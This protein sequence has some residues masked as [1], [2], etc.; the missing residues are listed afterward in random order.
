MPGLRNIPKI[1][2]PKIKQPGLR[3][4]SPTSKKGVIKISSYFQAG[5]EKVAAWNGV[6]RRVPGMRRFDDRL[7]ATTSKHELPPEAS[8]I[9]GKLAPKGKD[10]GR[11]LK[12]SGRRKGD[13]AQRLRNSRK[14]AVND[15][16]HALRRLRG[17]LH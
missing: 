10:L 11:R 14:T 6:N 2:T 4:K 15:I 16:S 5:F 1:M 7:L 8:D 12:F 3:M 17:R 9:M 13:V